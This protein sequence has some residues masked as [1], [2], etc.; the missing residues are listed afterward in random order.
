LIGHI[1]LLPA[2]FG[3]VILP[4]TVQSEL[5]SRK[6]PPCVQHWTANPPSWLEVC[7][8][9]FGHPD[10]LSLEGLDVGEKAVILLAVTLNADL[11]IMDDRK[12]V[13]TARSKGF[14]VTGTQ[15]FSSWRRKLD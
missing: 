14:R 9:A 8:V 12:A 7:D 11:L 1:D 3:K 13:K 10:N 15:A 4:V 6:A 2:L 5:V